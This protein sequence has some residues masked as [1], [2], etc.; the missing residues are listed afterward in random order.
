LVLQNPFKMGYLSVQTM[1]QVLKGGSVE[2]RI[3]TGTAFITKRNLEEPEI[4]ELVQPDLKKWL[5][6]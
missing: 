6:E 4:K 1:S 2:P 5:K 3:D